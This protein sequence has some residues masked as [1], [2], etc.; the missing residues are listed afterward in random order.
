MLV[1]IGATA[2][3]PGP[4]RPVAIN[5]SGLFFLKLPSV[6]VTEVLPAPRV[7]ERTGM[8]W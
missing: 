4:V 6:R 1:T 2:V 8:A 3:P 5:W 7:A